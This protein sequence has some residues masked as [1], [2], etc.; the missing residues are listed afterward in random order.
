[1]IE[2][3]GKCRGGRSAAAAVLFGDDFLETIGL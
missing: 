1:M 2:L 3:P